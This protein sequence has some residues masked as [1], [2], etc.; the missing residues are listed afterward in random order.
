MIILP[1]K[2]KIIGEKDNWARFEIEG[3]YPGYGVTVGN[4][5]RRV[6]LSSLEGAAVTHTKIKGVSHEFSTI[7]GVMEDAIA[8]MMN[9]KQLRFKIHS[10]E[11]QKA[12]LKVKGEKEVKGSDFNLPTQVELINKTCHIATITD[13]KT[14]LEIE[15]QIETGIGY[16]PIE[17][18]KEKEKLEI[19]VLPVDAIY[20]PMKRVSFKVENMRVGERTDFDRLIIDIETDGTIDAKSAFSKAVEI[21]TAH[22]DLIGSAFE[23]EKVE[24]KKIDSSKEEEDNEVKTKIEEMKLSSRTANALINSGIKTAGGI[25]QRSEKNILE[26]EGMGEKGVKEIKRELK[27]LGL[28][29]KE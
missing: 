16:Q 12:T 21:L 13:K 4:S 28:E 8:I 10:E 7:E 1:K 15:I 9:L 19:G 20:T 27:K 22:F 2:P 25:V 23:E 18:R 11:P 26:I 3:L 17:M 5:M 24:K 6:L 29:I 14:E